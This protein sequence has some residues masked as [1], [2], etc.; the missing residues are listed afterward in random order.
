MREITVTHNK[1]KDPLTYANLAQIKRLKNTIAELEARIA[2]L[3]RHLFARNVID[4][5]LPDDLTKILPTL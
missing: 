5:E 4:V 3:E 2:A 1:S